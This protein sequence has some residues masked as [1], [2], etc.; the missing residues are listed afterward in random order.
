MGKAE[1]DFMAYYRENMELTPGIKLLGEVPKT[2]W[3][4]IG[5]AATS[6]SGMCAYIVAAGEGATV[7]AMISSIVASSGAFGAATAVVK[8]AGIVGASAAA[9]YLGACIASS[10][11][12]AYK[13]RESFSK[14]FNASLGK[15]QYPPPVQGGRFPN[16]PRNYMTITEAS[17]FL[18]SNCN[19]TRMPYKVQIEFH[20]YPELLKCH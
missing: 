7:E 3:G 15:L 8:I 16:T 6:L 12:A 17:A 14:S 10:M 13:V 9:Y 5:V 20:K 4:N 19:N 1:K 18:R 11:V 2:L